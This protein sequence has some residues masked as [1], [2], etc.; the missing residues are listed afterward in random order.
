MHYHALHPLQE[1]SSLSGS[2]FR[3][4]HTVLEHSVLPSLLFMFTVTPTPTPSPRQPPS[5]FCPQSSFIIFY[6]LKAVSFSLFG[7]P[8]IVFYVLL[9]LILYLILYVYMLYLREETNPVCTG[10]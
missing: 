3:V 7:L 4:V 8:G 1:D 2:V 10:T 9:C 6:T 5:A